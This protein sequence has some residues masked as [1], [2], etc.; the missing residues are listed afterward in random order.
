[1]NKSVESN[2]QVLNHVINL[3]R[4][5][6]TFKVS[7]KVGQTAE[8]G[9]QRLALTKEDKIMRDIFINWLEKEGFDVRSD[10]FGNIWLNN[11]DNSDIIR[12]I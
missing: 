9:V 3:E 7:N 1:M 2:K 5:M 10:D 4:C 11:P 12:S 8:T 6:E